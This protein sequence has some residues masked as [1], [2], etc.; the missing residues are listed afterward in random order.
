MGTRLFVGNL[1]FSTTEDTLRMALSEGGR[2]V[3]DVHMPADR[4]T[5]R[6]RGFAFAEMGSEADAKAAI[7]ALDGK[8]LDG[9]PLKVNEA[10]ERPPRTGGG[11]GGGSRGGYSGGGGGR[12]GG[13]GGGGYGG[14][15]GGR[16][17]Y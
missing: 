3:K 8:Q 2:T 14:G 5:G 15:G 11:G 7:A 16:R 17:D 10:E 6:P 1:S 9:R 13:G 4:E 12:G